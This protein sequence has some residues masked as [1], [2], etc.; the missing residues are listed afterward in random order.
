MAFSFPD[1]LFWLALF[2]Y[3]SST[4][5]ETRLIIPEDH[6]ESQRLP[7]GLKSTPLP[8]LETASS[9]SMLTIYPSC[10]KPAI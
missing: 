6:R 5:L 10:I 8:D 4:A 1:R 3:F 9:E 7:A 2:H